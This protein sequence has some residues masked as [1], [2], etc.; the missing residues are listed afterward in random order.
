MAINLFTRYPNNTETQTAQVLE[1]YPIGKARNESFPG[2]KDF[3]PIEATWVN[4]LLG[5]LGALMTEVGAVPD[6]DPEK[7]T[8]SQYLTALQSLSVSLARLV[9]GVVALST[10]QISFGSPTSGDITISKHS[11]VDAKV[12][13][14]KTTIDTTYRHKFQMVQGG[15]RFIDSP[16]NDH[17]KFSLVIPID[18]SFVN[19]TLDPG[20]SFTVN[21]QNGVTGVPIPG[22]HF[23][24]VYR[25]SLTL[26]GTTPKAMGTFPLVCSWEE[27]GTPPGDLLT[28]MFGYADLNTSFTFDIGNF[29]T[30][31]LQIWVDPDAIF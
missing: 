13:T 4:E 26:E 18:M 23:G 8:A 11:G 17:D 9:P 21:V 25:A 14:A 12:E 10:G 19:F 2:A 7:A 5:L 1:E 31:F 22:V 29:D 15:L 28:L 24:T 30:A 3:F 27:T 6:G 16:G 20:V